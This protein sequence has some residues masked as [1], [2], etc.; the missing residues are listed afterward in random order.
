MS[1]PNHSTSDIEDAFSSMNI[2][3]YTLVS[4]D[5]VPASSESSSFN[6]LKNSKDNMILL[7]FS[8]FYNN[9]CLNEVQAFYAKESPISP[10]APITSQTVLTPSPLITNHY[11]LVPDISLFL[12]NY[13]HLRSKS[14]PY[15]LTQLRRS[16]AET[17]AINLVANQQLIV[18]GIAELWCTTKTMALVLSI[19]NRNTRLYWNSCKQMGNYKDSLVSTLY[20]MVRKGAVAS[21]T[22]LRDKSTVLIGNVTT[23]KPQNLEEATNTSQRITYNNKSITMDYHNSRIEGKKTFQDFAATMGYWNH[24]CRERC[25]ASTLDL[26]LSRSN[27][28]TALWSS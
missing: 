24:P 1:S 28:A 9:P 14:I 25:T 22:G 7:V 2:L 17:Q 3:N 26:A 16:T 23:S 15:L 8:P 6:S 27:D 20:L 18:H 11:Y 19:P 4:S 21:F 5:Y 12:N 10:P 13:Y